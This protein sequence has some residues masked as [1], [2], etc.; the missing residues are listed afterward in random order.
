M[1]HKIIITILLLVFTPLFLSAEELESFKTGNTYGY[2]N[3]SGKVVIT[4]KFDDANSFSEG[5]AAVLQNGKWGFIDKK[6]NFVIPAKFDESWS[7]SEGCREPQAPDADRGNLAIACLDVAKSL[8]RQIGCN[9][10]RNL[11]GFY[12]PGIASGRERYLR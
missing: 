11:H 9:R 12:F 2:K 3:E 4:A 8:F 7:F 1:Q 10:R 6:G 5:L